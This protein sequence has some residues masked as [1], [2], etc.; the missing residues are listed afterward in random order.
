M[1]QEAN[2]SKDLVKTMAQENRYKFLP[3]RLCAFAREQIN[4]VTVL[5]TLVFI[6][7]VM[8]DSAGS[9][10]EWKQAIG[11]W[12]WSFPRDHG[13]HPDFRTEWWYFTGNLHDVEGNRYGYQLTFFRQGLRKDVPDLDN[14][15]T[16]RDVYF[17]HFTVT[18]VAAEHFQ[19]AERISRT[20]PGLAGASEGGMDVWLLDWSAVMADSLITVSAEDNGMSLDLELRPRK[21]L[22]FHGENGLSTKGAAAGQ[23]SYYTSFTDLESRGTLKPH[24]DVA[25]VA[26]E[27]TSWF[28]QEFGSNQLGDDQV[29]WDWFSL[30]LADGRDV[31]V[32]LLLKKDGSPDPAS[33]GT[34]IEP[35]GSAH[36]LELKEISLETLD[37]WKSPHSHG[38]YPSRW[39]LSVPAGN[40]T[41]D[42]APLIADQELNTTGS[43]SVTYW[44]GAVGVTGKSNGKPVTGG[45]IR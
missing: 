28:D 23:A 43:V 42:V 10:A 37:T 18:D 20:G 22:V 17:A 7:M 27:G 25:A 2:D 44:E 11:P 31:M 19:V 34:L 4:A 21:P 38:V 40:I 29:G 16:V 5:L 15:W 8:V 35:D 1:T 33:S 12:E 3:L 30:H 26:V 36:H 24:A 13:S 45:R 39:R 14:P 32:Y 9:E 6:A 41:L